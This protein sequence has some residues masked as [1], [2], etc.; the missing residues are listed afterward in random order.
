MVKENRSS[1]QERGPLSGE[2]LCV[3]EDLSPA[4]SPRSGPTILLHPLRL[5]AQNER[6]YQSRLPLSLLL[7]RTLRLPR[8]L[9]SS[10]MHRAPPIVQVG[11][12][13]QNLTSCVVRTC[14]SRALRGRQRRS[15]PSVV[16]SIIHVNAF[17]LSACGFCLDIV[18]STPESLFWKRQAIYVFSF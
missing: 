12:E 11:A 15:R 10:L 18:H 2:D 9:E 16:A 6:G 14:V 3:C 8:P 7:L 1:R 4:D 5:C 13:S 17:L